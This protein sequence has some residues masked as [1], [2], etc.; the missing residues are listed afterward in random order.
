VTS[1]APVIRVFDTALDAVADVIAGSADIAAI[2]AASVLARRLQAGRLRLTGVSAPERLTGLFADTPTWNEQG[3]DCIVGAWRGVTGPAGITSAQVLLLGRCPA[4]RRGAAVLWQELSRLSWS[5]MYRDGPGIACLSCGGAS[6]VRHRLGRPRA[7]ES[8]AKRASERQRNVGPSN[9][10]ALPIE[11]L[12]LGGVEIVLVEFLHVR[13]QRLGQLAPLDLV[14]AQRALQLVMQRLECIV[15]VDAGEAGVV[16]DDFPRRTSRCACPRSWRA[17]SRHRALAFLHRD[18]DRKSASVDQRK[19]GGFSLGD[20]ADLL[21]ITGG[22]GAADARHA[23]RPAISSAPSS[24]MPGTRCARSTRRI[25]LQ[26]VAVVIDAGF[27]EAD[28]RLMPFASS[29]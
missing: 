24:P 16:V 14:V 29:D 26:H 17:G 4:C 25:S 23:E 27:V 8:A 13:Q 1:I 7:S 6:R 11:R 3:V 20:G 2:T 28:R 18:T 22:L 10:R 9:A 19:I 12:V 5:A 21:A 15:A